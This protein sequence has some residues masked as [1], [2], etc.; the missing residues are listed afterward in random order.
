MP[1]RPSSRT[2]KPKVTEKDLQLA[3]QNQDARV[4]EEVRA[5]VKDGVGFAPLKGKLFKVDLDIGI[6]PLMEWAVAN[7]SI[8]PDNAPQLAALFYMLKDIV[9]PEDWDDFRKH[10]RDTRAKGPDFV[11]FQESVTEVVA[12]LPTGQSETS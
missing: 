9:D 6:M 4:P 5:V 12:S 10:A 7:D 3:V 1:A 8:E 11:A 2:T